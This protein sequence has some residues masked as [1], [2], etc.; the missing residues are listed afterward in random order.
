MARLA[1]PGLLLPHH[2]LP[3]HSLVFLGQLSTNQHDVKGR[4]A[5]LTPSSLLLTRFI[6]NLQSYP[7]PLFQVLL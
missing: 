6:V 1:L 2:V 7:Q 3:N 4:L 5:A